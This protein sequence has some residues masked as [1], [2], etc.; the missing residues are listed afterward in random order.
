MVWL[1]R[2]L[3]GHAHLEMGCRIHAV[4][5]GAHD[6]DDVLARPGEAVNRLSVALRVMGLGVAVRS[7]LGRP[8]AVA[9]VSCLVVDIGAKS[10]HLESHRLA[11]ADLPRLR[12]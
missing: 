4:V 7:H 2:C 11:G 5:A 9:E 3:L 6:A 1:S 8:R 12:H 10:P